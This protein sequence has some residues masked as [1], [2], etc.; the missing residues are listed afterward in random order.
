MRTTVLAAL[1]AACL[2]LLPAP[3]RGQVSV[4][5][6]FTLPL[7]ASPPLV[8]VRPGVQVVEG[9]DEE[10]FYTEGAYWARRDGGWYRARSPRAAF[11]FVEPRRVPVRLVRLPPGHSKHWKKHHAPRPPA[12]WEGLDG[13]DHGGPPHGKAKGHDKR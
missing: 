10:V 9:S 11:A 7:P 1:S 2:Q 8:V 3:A 13:H 5:I 4:G 12:R 6:D